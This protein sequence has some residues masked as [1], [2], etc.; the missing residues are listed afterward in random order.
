MHGVRPLVSGALV[1]FSAVS[2]CGS[3]LSCPNCS[4]AR[5]V[6]A[7]VYDATFWPNLLLV[8]LPLFVLAAICRQLYGVGL[9][10]KAQ[11]RTQD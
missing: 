2:W 6:R 9:R 10:E 5:V 8:L 1:A 3:A 7:S 11:R 4:T